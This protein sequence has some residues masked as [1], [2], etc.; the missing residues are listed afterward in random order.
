MNDRTFL[1]ECYINILTD[2]LIT[3]LTFTFL[4]YLIIFV[5]FT[6]QIVSDTHDIR[7]INEY[8]RSTDEVTKDTN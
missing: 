7:L 8:A 3:I 1:F 5:I 2:T 4:P 6:L